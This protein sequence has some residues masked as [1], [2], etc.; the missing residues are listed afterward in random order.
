VG[1]GLIKRCH[2]ARLYAHSPACRLI[3]FV[4]IIRAERKLASERGEGVVCVRDH[5]KVRGRK[6][7]GEKSKGEKERIKAARDEEEGREGKTQAE[8]RDKFI[9]P[10]S[11][12]N[13]TRLY[14][15]MFT[16]R[17]PSQ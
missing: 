14:L 8:E 11:L 3:R 4:I 13:P 10:I 7:E 6:R 9:N 17:A 5:V 15:I 2:C 1:G 16:E 12:L